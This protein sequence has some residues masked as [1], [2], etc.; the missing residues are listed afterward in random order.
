MRGRS[1]GPVVGA[2]AELMEGHQLRLG[3][4]GH[5]LAIPAHHLR[6]RAP[7][8]GRVAR[9]ENAFDDAA[10]QRLVELGEHR[11]LVPPV[12]DVADDELARHQL[13]HQ[14]EALPIAFAQPLARMRARP[15][16]SVTPSRFQSASMRG[17][18]KTLS[19][20]RPAIDG[21]GL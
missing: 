8:L 17:C 15:S 11:V 4:G 1:A 19:S 10:V 13:V 9:A 3:D 16:E 2:V 6:P 12:G 14:R 5:G 20:K 7:L 21:F 18:Q